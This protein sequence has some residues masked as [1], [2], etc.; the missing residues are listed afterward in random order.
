MKP[1]DEWV[2]VSILK[3]DSTV[4]HCTTSNYHKIKLQ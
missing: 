3:Q 2:Y 4:D 1:L